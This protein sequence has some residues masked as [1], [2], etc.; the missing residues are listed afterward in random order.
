M[1]LVREAVLVESFES[2]V[3]VS[4]YIRAPSPANTQ[5]V[6]RGIDAYLRMLLQNNF[7]HSDMHPGAWAGSVLR[8]CSRASGSAARDSTSLSSVVSSTARRQHSGGP[9]RPQ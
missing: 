2:G 3:T 4:G 6:A 8:G 7:V 5:I 9:A 1:E